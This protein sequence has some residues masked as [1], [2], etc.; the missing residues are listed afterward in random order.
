MIMEMK[1][2]M[3]RTIRFPLE[4]KYLFTVLEVIGFKCDYLIDNQVYMKDDSGL[5]LCIIPPH[6]G[7]NFNWII[8]MEHTEAFN[9]WGDT[10]YQGAVESLTGSIIDDIVDDIIVFRDNAD[11]YLSALEID[12]E[13]MD[14][15]LYQQFKIKQV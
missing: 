9:K 14:D 4:Q 11:A 2:I 7:T 3:K 13:I 5:L 6:K 8:R 12:I 1:E 15:L 10:Y